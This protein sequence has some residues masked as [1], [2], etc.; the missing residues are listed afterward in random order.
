M[1]NREKK[2][3]Q[4]KA[5]EALNPKQIFLSLDAGEN[6]IIQIFWWADFLHIHI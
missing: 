5:K 6:I 4:K 3:N 2:N 1:S